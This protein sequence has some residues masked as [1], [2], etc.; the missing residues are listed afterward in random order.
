MQIALLAS[1]GECRVGS[2]D[3]TVLTT[4]S[5]SRGRRDGGSRGQ[6]QGDW[7]TSRSRGLGGWV[8]M[9]ADPSVTQEIQGLKGTEAPAE[10]G[11]LGGGV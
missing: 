2:G 4:W 3:G 8:V 7:G 9:Y 11:A 6:G 1:L 5:G 10:P